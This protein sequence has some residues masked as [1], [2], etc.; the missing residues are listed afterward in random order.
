MLARRK[1]PDFCYPCRKHSLYDPPTS[2][3]QPTDR[4]TAFYCFAYK[5]PTCYCRSH[6]YARWCI[7]D[8]DGI[9]TPICMITGTNSLVRLL[10]Y[11]C[12]QLHENRSLSRSLARCRRYINQNQPSSLSPPLFRPARKGRKEED[13][14]AVEPVRPTFEQL[15][16]R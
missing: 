7:H 5:L 4:P 9:S 1:Q 11:F 14:G 10:A 2:A 13:G 6:I 12:S 8:L 3:V 15:E 16:L